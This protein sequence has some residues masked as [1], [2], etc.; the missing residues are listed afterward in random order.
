MGM[1]VLIVKMTGVFHALMLT[2]GAS[3]KV[4]HWL[5][6]WDLEGRAQGAPR[7]VIELR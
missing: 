4:D 1:P 5:S 3:N 7:L 2:R 6:P